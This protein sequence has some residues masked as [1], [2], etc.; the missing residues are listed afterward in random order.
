MRVV[1]Y[2]LGMSKFLCD[3][4]LDTDLY[5]PSMYYNDK[6][7]IHVYFYIHLHVIY[8]EKHSVYFKFILN[9]RIEITDSE[10]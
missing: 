8:L 10:K 4:Q 2:L 6:G 1:N 5:L 3:R 9:K 7:S